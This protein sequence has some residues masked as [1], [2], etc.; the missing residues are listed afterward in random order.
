MESSCSHLHVH[1]RYLLLSM[2]YITSLCSISISLS[3]R[4]HSHNLIHTIS[5][6]VSDSSDVVVGAISFVLFLIVETKV[7]E[8]PAVP[9]LLLVKKPLLL[10]ILLARFFEFFILVAVVSFLPHWY[11]LV[12]GDS[13]ALSGARLLPIM[14]SFI[15]ASIFSGLLLSSYVSHPTLPSRRTLILCREW[16]GPSPCWA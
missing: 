11:S 10:L 5:H 13:P 16:L 7:S 1:H 8:E 4:C 14:F 15:L 2:F 12:I 3:T 9:V 6:H